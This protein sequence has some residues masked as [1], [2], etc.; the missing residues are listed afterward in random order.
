MP[1]EKKIQDFVYLI[2]RKRIINA[3]IIRKEIFTNFYSATI[4][5]TRIYIIDIQKKK[6][7]SEIP[8]NTPTSISN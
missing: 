6:N 1:F 4:K 2:L 7:R 8:R 3:K 5:E